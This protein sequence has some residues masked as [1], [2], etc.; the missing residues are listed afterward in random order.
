MQEFLI[1]SYATELQ[2]KEVVVTMSA[3]ANAVYVTGA[4]ARVGRVV[5]DRPLTA[6]EAIMESGGFIEEKAN[7]KKVTVIRYLGDQ[8]TVYQ[9][10]LGPIMTGG[11]VPPFYL[12]P[13]DIVH[14]PAKV[15][16]F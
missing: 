10:N 8:N 5:M 13:R 15:Q 6:L 14:V 2:D 7:L 4:V 16:W 9:L 11:P 1:K 12:R 3:S